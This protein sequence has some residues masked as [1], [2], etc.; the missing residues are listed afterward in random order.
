MFDI[1][2]KDYTVKR[3]HEWFDSTEFI[4]ELCINIKD[5]LGEEH[6]Y[7]YFSDV[8]DE[9]FANLLLKKTF[10][11]NSTKKLLELLATP[12]FL[13]GEEEKRIIYKKIEK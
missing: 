5:N 13:K 1:P 6:L 10:I 3:I 12:I 9:L 7:D 2:D 4:R 8:H 11:S